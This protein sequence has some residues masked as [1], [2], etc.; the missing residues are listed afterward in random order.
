MLITM[1]VQNFKTAKRNIRYSAT[2]TAK[3]NYDDDHATVIDGA[4]SEKVTT[5]KVSA[6]TDLA[7]N[8]RIIIDTEIMLHQKYQ[9]SKCN[10]I[11]WS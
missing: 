2:P 5:F 6:T 1:L 11:S 10:C 9:W 8:Q 7:A 4:I 3:K